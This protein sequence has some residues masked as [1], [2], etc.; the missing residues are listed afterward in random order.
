M[1]LL[2]NKGGTPSRMDG[3]SQKIANPICHAGLGRFQRPAS[4]ATG[5]HIAI[6]P[7]IVKNIAAAAPVKKLR[8]WNPFDASLFARLR[9]A[10]ST[11]SAAAGSNS[12]AKE[13]ST[14]IARRESSP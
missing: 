12:K 10:F 3:R 7:I 2:R 11:R 9:I 8:T 4:Q 13:S 14:R 5:C 6:E 1:S